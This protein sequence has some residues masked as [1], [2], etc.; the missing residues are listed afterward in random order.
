MTGGLLRGDQLQAEGLEDWRLVLDAL[1][2]RLLTGSYATGARL[3]TRI[4]AAAEAAD[5][6][7]DLD[8]RYAHLN[9]RLLSH[10]AGGVTSRD[11]RLAR[12]I[13][14]LAA[15]EGVRA[16]P[17]VVSTLELALDTADLAAVKPFWRAV[18]GLGDT[19]LPDELVD[20]A[21]ALPNLWFQAT[22]PHPEP[23]QR[24]H[25]DVHVPHDAAEARIAAALA[26]GGVLVSDA[27]APSFTV[28]ADAEGNKA[29]VC[30]WQGRD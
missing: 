1:R 12:T 7:P 24:F 2:T 18:L 11:V 17:S 25:L 3:L 8:L 9:V 4:A 26:A 13:S 30:T 20:A 29:C 22:D 5:H 21:G 19:A 14:E 6:H 27:E 28:L 23:R 16:D 10:D 15:D